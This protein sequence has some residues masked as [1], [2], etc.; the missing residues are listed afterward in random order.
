MSDNLK[1][2][3]EA[4]LA[5]KEAAEKRR[6]ELQARY[7]QF[8]DSTIAMWDNLNLKEEKFTLKDGTCLSVSN[9]GLA[10]NGPATH[11]ILNEAEETI[12]LYLDAETKKYDEM[13]SR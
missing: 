1:K 11:A 3:Y 5:A 7:E 10:F 12:A 13:Y 4:A 2:S 6:N 9:K 8:K